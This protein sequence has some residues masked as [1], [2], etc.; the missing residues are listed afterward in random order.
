MKLIIQII[1]SEN[2]EINYSQTSNKNEY[3]FIMPDSDVTIIPSYEKVKNSVVVDDNEHSKE[4]IIEVEDATAVVYE[5]RVKFTVIA[6]EGYEVE[7]ILITDKEGNKI[8]Y[9]K[10]DKDNEYEF[11]MPDSDV[12]IQPLFKKIAN[13]NYIINPETGRNCLF[14]VL[15]MII[16]FTIKITKRKRLF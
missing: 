13:P 15:I 3:K 10:T 6:E 2:H 5:D 12:I 11:I 9:K 8:E 16:I 14:F 7:N 4:I 1:D